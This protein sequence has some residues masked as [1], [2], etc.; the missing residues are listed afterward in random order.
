[1]QNFLYLATVTHS[2]DHDEQFVAARVD[3][4]YSRNPHCSKTLL[5][6]CKQTLH[7]ST[8]VHRKAPWEKRNLVFL[9]I[10]FYQ[11]GG[12]GTQLAWGRRGGQ[13][14]LT[15]HQGTTDQRKEMDLSRKPDLPTS[16]PFAN[17]C[18]FRPKKTYSAQRLRLPQLSTSNTPCWSI[19]AP[20]FR[21]TAPIESKVNVSDVNQQSFLRKSAFS[22]GILLWLQSQEAFQEATTTKR[23]PALPAASTSKWPSHCHFLNGQ[24]PRTFSANQHCTWMIEVTLDHTFPFDSIQYRKGPAREHYISSVS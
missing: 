1:V 13:T 21:Y 20:Q 3:N 5:R 18:T 6:I 9:L 15:V 17:G 12:W 2:K 23:L 7:Q 4:F 11:W 24:A 22:W 19:P 10:W 14:Q 16:T 8:Q